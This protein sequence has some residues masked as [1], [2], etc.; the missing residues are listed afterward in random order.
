LNNIW[1]NYYLVKANALGPDVQGVPSTS[2]VLPR[3]ITTKGD[4]D[5]LVSTIDPA[6]PTIFKNI[7]T[8][9]NDIDNIIDPNYGLIAGLNCKLMG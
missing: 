1:K 4:I 7:L 5:L 2:G 9:L 8:D 3:L 6:L